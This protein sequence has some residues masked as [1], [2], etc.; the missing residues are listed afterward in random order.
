MS[1]VWLSWTSES[2]TVFYHRDGKGFIQFTCFNGNGL[3][4]SRKGSLG[5]P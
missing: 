1:S 4:V 3:S 2:D 5:L